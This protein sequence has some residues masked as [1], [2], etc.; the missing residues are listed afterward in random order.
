MTKQKTYNQISLEEEALLIA[1]AKR[2]IN[3]YEAIYNLFYEAVFRFIFRRIDEEQQSAD[4]TSQVFLKG[5]DHI[6]RYEHRGISYLAWLYRT[7]SNEINAFYRLETKNRVIS[8]GESEIERI[9]SE[10]EPDFMNEKIKLIIQFLE[11]LSSDE[12][13]ILELKYFENQSFKEIGYVLGKK[14]SNV[15][16]KL[17]RALDKLKAMFAR[18][19]I[20]V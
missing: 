17:Y 13:T 20:T 12:I 5:M 3:D 9:F 8:L 18:E 7:A 2:N 19:G 16:M 15:K 1:A 11:K 14:E 4:L 6:D 10:D